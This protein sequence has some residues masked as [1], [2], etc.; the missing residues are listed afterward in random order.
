MVNP[1]L[2]DEESI[3][4]AKNI[5]ESIVQMSTEVGISSLSVR[6]ILIVG[7]S[8]FSSD[9][10]RASTS[11]AQ[12]SRRRLSNENATNYSHTSG[13]TIAAAV[14]DLSKTTNVVLTKITDE[15]LPGESAFSYNDAN[16]GLS[17]RAE[18]Q[19]ISNLAGNTFPGAT[20]SFTMPSD[21][22]LSG[23]LKLLSPV[24]SKRCV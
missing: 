23:K 7:S 12:N 19:D 9:L 2:M 13:T 20:G 14:K 22:P 15:M 21:L 17:M 10:R 16:G 1:E 6:S 5:S 4:R 8:F 18:V 3:E 11:G 24:V